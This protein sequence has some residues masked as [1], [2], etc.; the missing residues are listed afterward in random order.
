M[1]LNDRERL[2]AI[3]TIAR[4]GDP[5]RYAA[6]L[7]VADAARDDLLS[8]GA[9]N[10]ELARVAELVK[11]PQLGEIRLQWWRDS[12]DRALNGDTAEHPVL[13]AVAQT[14]RACALPTEALRGMIDARSFDVSTRVMPD[15]A[16]LEAYLDATAGTLFRLAAR[17]I[18]VRT[19]APLESSNI[20]AASRQAALAYGLVGLMRALPVHARLGRVDLP[21]DALLE[22]GTSPS[23]IL[24]G[25][26]SSGLMEVL[27]RLRGRAGDC[28]REANR[29]V[30]D[31]QP[32]VR[33]AF[34]PLALVRP[35]MTALENIDNPLQ[36]IADINPLYRFWRLA[37]YKFR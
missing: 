6:A 30:M 37:T 3:R 19:S 29:R 9:F 12:L 5:D 35:Y 33:Q 32:R 2:D 31:L 18:A 27:A 34:R 26:T 36:Q 10:V 8:L 22:Q 15:Q 11:E 28:L 4:E 16:T 7:F 23:L 17:V 24:T 14:V 20:H 21:E 25:E 1:A 13:A